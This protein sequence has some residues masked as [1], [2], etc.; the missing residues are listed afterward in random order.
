ME[1]EEV[2]DEVE[3]NKPD[4]ITPLISINAL[5]GTMGFHML[6]VTGRKEKHLV[7]ILIGSGSTHN[8]LNIESA[9][10][11]QYD[12]LSIKP[13]T[14]EVANGSTMSCT[15]MCKDFK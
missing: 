9:R 14:V 10:K 8:F 5:E 2:D 4:T 11:L 3:E 6:R 7:F 15:A 1:D 13:L 12:W